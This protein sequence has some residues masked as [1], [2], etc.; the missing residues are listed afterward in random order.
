MYISCAVRNEW[1]GELYYYG[2]LADCSKSGCGTAEIRIPFTRYMPE[3]VVVEIFSEEANGD[4]YTDFCSEPIIMKALRKNHHKWTMT[5]FSGETHTHRWDQDTW[6]TNDDNHWHDCKAASCPFRE[7]NDL[8]DGYG[9]HRY[10][11]KIEKYE[12]KVDGPQCDRPALLAVSGGAWLAL[13]RRRRD[14]Q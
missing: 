14:R 1:T 9:W 11:Q 13:L 6:I 2:K 7:S 5:D 10:D 4:L 3:N 8:K 12:Y